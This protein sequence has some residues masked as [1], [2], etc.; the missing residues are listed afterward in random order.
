MNVFNPS[1]LYP[2]I[3]ELKNYIKPMVEMDKTPNTEGKY[4]W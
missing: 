4:P 2:R 1:T 3:D